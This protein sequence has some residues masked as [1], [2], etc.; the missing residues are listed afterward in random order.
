MGEQ[1]DL[2]KSQLKS[3][4]SC[5]I[6]KVV[7]KILKQELVKEIFIFHLP[8][9]LKHLACQGSDKKLPGASSLHY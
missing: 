6:K 8:F 3:Y 9:Q 4:Q 5:F 7:K 2:Q 1:V